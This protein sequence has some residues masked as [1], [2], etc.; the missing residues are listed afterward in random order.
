M[1][2]EHQLILQ[3]IKIEKLFSQWALTYYLATAHHI[4]I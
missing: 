4:I 1:A 3:P 2:N